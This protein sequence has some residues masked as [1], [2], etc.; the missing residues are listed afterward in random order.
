MSKNAR[1]KEVALPISEELAGLFFQGQGDT[2]ELEEIGEQTLLLIEEGGFDYELFN[3]VV[4]NTQ[5]DIINEFKSSRDASKVR[6]GVGD[7][8]FN[9]FKMRPG[10]EEELIG[11]LYGKWDDRL[12]PRIIMKWLVA[13]PTEKEE[14]AV[15]RFL[16]HLAE[17]DREL[18]GEKNVKTRMKNATRRNKEVRNARKGLSA[19]RLPAN[20]IEHVLLPMLRNTRDKAAPLARLVKEEEENVS[21]PFGLCRRRRRKTRRNH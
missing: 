20:V 10:R 9:V 1:R 11:V 3:Y 17:G 7:N 18:T 14:F 21:C 5:I 4:L 13:K 15:A 19:S 2:F 12:G 8:S 6:F 16:H